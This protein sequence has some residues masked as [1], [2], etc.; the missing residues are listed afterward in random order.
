MNSPRRAFIMSSIEQYLA[1]IINVTV[2]ATMARLLTPDAIGHAVIALGIG[3]IALSLREFV[4]PDFL[5]Q[6]MEVVQSDI[7]TS[8]TVLFMMTTVVA[9]AL[10][11]F[12]EEIAAFYDAPELSFFLFVMTMSAFADVVAQPIIALLR[13]DMAFGTLAK[14]RTLALLVSALTTIVLGSLGVGYISY[15]WGM[16][17]NS[18]MLALITVAVVPHSIGSIC[19]PSL[20]S[21]RAVLAFGGFKG[22]SQAVDRI[23]EAVPQLIIGKAMSMT[24]AG[25][26]NRAN[27]VC[28]IP[29]R[30]IMSAFYAMAFPTLAAS[31]RDGKDIKQA[32]LHTLSYLSVLYWPGVLMIAVTADPIV[33]LVLG[34]RWD[35]AILLVRV[36]S[37]AA[38]FW[39]A[40]I[41]TNPLLLALGQN[42]D[43]FLSSFLSRSVAATVLCGASTYSVVVVALSQ[44]VSLPAQMLIAIYFAKKHLAFT[45]VELLSAVWPSVFVTSLSLLGPLVLLMANGGNTDFTMVQFGSSILS[46]GMGWVLGLVMTR[47]P[48]LVE[49]Q[50][51]LKTVVGLTSG[52]RRWFSAAGA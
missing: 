27:T 30:I 39:F 46:A 42:R 33:H 26:Y 19:R 10:L 21:W 48:F 29:D 7:R 13:R 4:T 28:G 45:L 14:I 12:S 37:V 9:A 11:Y 16:L 38:V 44:F 47:H 15:V 1:L 50:L 20:A 40:V 25:L 41:V 43:A 35:E 6:K 8:F 17:A 23:Y 32:Y 2:M 34:P 49:V 24:S 22:A 5:I 31:V 51:I 18:L 3:S 52:L 36:M